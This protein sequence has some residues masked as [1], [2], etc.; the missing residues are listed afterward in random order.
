[1]EEGSSDLRRCKDPQL[2]SPERFHKKTSIPNG[3]VP[4]LS[5]IIIKWKVAG[6]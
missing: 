4:C 6:Y 3:M 5:F 2:E 1:M